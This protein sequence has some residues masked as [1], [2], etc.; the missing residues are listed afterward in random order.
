MATP[1]PQ[2]ITIPC[3]LA[4]PEVFVPKSVNGGT[5]KYSLTMQFP[6]DGHPL[7]SNAPSLYPPTEKVVT[8]DGIRRMLVIAAKEKWGDDRSK[9]PGVLRTMDWKSYFS[10]TGQDGWPLRD[11]D[12]HPEWQGYEG[13]CFVRASAAEYAPQVFDNMKNPITDQRAVY[14]GLICRALINAFAYDNKGNRG[15]S[16]GFNGL[17]ILANDGTVYGGGNAADAFGAY[18]DAG[19]GD[20][21]DAG[22]GLPGNDDVPF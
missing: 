1:K 21:F 2:I 11:G 18:G 16:L 3:R 5:A 9:W 15:V 17:Q 19:G 6:K 7:V 4:F 22:G 12:A 13:M 14:G 10:P 8:V 20:P